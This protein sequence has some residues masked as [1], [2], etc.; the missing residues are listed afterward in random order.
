M[1]AIKH[2][3]DPDGIINQGRCC[4]QRGIDQTFGSAEGGS[5]RR[6]QRHLPRITCFVRGEY[7]RCTGT[8]RPHIAALIVAQERLHA[9][10]REHVDGESKQVEHSPDVS[11][12]RRAVLPPP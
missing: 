1:R 12:S 9:T 4:R 6:C 5:S 11:S 10:G 2:A 3:L 8:H 7:P